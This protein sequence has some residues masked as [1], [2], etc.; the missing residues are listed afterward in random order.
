MALEGRAAPTLPLLPGLSLQCVECVG[1]GCAARPG[2]PV[3][4][5]RWSQGL[6]AGAAAEASTS[7]APPRLCC[8]R[9]WASLHSAHSSI[10]SVV[11]CRASRVRV[12]GFLSP[13][14]TG[15]LFPSRLPRRS[16]RP[17][18]RPTEPGSSCSL[19]RGRGD[20]WRGRLR[21]SP[22]TSKRASVPGPLPASARSSALPRL[23]LSSS[24]Q[25]LLFQLSK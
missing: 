8:R 21:F 17:P 20:A 18:R 24:P 9:T 15:Q 12:L 13:L 10:F 2:A 5:W 1:R 22:T 3:I 19:G 6:A 25:G 23:C 16:R 7:L 11:L 4:T 14:L